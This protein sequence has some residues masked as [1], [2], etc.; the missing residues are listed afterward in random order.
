M[1]RDPA[2]QQC[3]HHTR[4]PHPL[5]GKSACAA[6]HGG[7]PR[8]LRALRSGRH[9]AT[10][11]ARMLDR[12]TRRL[13]CRARPGDRNERAADTGQ[14]AQIAAGQDPAASRRIRTPRKAVESRTGRSRAGAPG[15][16]PPR[17]MAGRKGAVDGPAGAGAVRCPAPAQPSGWNAGP[18]GRVVA[19]VPGRARC[20]AARIMRLRAAQQGRRN[21]AGPCSLPAC[22][23]ARRKRRPAM[24]MSMCLALFRQQ[25][26]SRPWTSPWMATGTWTCPRVRIRRTSGR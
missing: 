15:R 18:S 13:A 16:A 20:R 14:L 2:L 17:L 4:I 23:P 26:R 5:P 10:R 24:R 25:R 19:R 9:A 21:G 1:Y 12:C 6:L 7:I 8:A 3:D 22:P 11:H